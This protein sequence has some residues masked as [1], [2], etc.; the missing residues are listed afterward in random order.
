[1]PGVGLGAPEITRRQNR[2][3]RASRRPVALVQPGARGECSG[4]AARLEFRRDK[5]L[6]RGHNVSMS[7]PGRYIVDPEDPR[8][9][10]LEEW[11]RLSVAEREQVV[12]QLPSEIE[13]SPPPEGDL[14]RIPKQRGLE[15]LDEFFRRAGRRVYL[16]SELPVYY[17]AERMFAPDLIA[18]TEVEPH[19]RMRWVVADEGKGLDLALEVTVEGSRKKDL[20]ENVSRYARLGIPEYFVFDRRSGRLHG[21]RLEEG[22]HHYAAIVPQHGRWESRVLGLELGV[23]GGRFR[24]YAGS[25]LLLENRELLDHANHLVDDLLGRLGAMEQE[26]SAS[27]AGKAQAEADKAQAEADKARAE[28]RVRELEAELARLRRER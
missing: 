21:W 7:A 1:M 25:A 9:P 8:A 12:Q 27:Q 6:G 3:V 28:Q 4:R 19:E 14:H 15:A 23:D 10:S 22:Q 26:L 18:V 16:S 5:A 13:S 17:P 11:E 2:H 20:E 24:F